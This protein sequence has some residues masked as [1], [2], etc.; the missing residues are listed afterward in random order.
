LQVERFTLMYQQID[1]MRAADVISERTAA[2]AKAQV[3]VKY[4]E[5]RLSGYSAMFGELAK[6]SSSGNRTLSAIGKAAAVTQA[7]I[8]GYLAIQKALASHPPPLN[9][10]M[11]AAIG[12]TTAA[13]VASILST[14]TNFATGGSFTVPGGMGGVDSQVVALRASPGE[15]ISVQTPTQVR[16]GTAAANGA[17][18]GG[19]GGAAPQVNNRIVNVLDPALLGDYL[20]TAEGE[21]VV[22]NVIRRNSDQIKQGLSNG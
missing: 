14:N 11:A 21:S 19:E 6:L 15:R 9:Y 17:S 20:A 5:A 22:L 12:V 16:H 3:N 1:A 7:T 4:Q 18:G 8:D 13:N 2:Q 10:A